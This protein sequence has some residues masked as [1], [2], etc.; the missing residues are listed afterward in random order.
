MPRTNDTIEALL[1]EYADLLSISGGDAF[2]VRTYDKAARSVGGYHAEISTLDEKG[3]LGI[4]NVGKSIAEKIQEYFR[5]GMINALEELR[6][7][8]PAGVRQ[9]ISIPGLGPKK[10][11]VLFKDL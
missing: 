3:I 5:K 6:A 4:P 2:R 7:Q 10:A 11:M 9:M 1:Q 8:V